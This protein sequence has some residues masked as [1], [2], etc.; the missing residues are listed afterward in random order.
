MFLHLFGLLLGLL[1]DLFWTLWL[2]YH[3]LRFGLVGFVMCLGGFACFG[4]V[5]FVACNLVSLFWFDCI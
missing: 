4:L 5:H 3:R 1:A 2:I